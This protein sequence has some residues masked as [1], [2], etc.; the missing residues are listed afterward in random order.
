M[1]NARTEAAEVAEKSLMLSDHAASR[2]PV[3]YPF[4]S[5]AISA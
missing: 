1:K 2:S 4:A 5:S 3:I